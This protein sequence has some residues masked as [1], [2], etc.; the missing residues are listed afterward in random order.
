MDKESFSKS[1][2][3][4]FNCGIQR[5]FLRKFWYREVSTNRNG[6]ERVYS[7]RKSAIKNITK[8]FGIKKQQQQKTQFKTIQNIESDT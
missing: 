4:S 5:F 2:N 7:T 6:E 8:P 3:S 1:D